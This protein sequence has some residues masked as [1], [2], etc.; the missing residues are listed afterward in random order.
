M[1]HPQVGYLNVVIPPD[2]V[3]EETSGDIMVPEGSPVKLTC[4]AHGY[5]EPTVKWRRED[6]APIILRSQGGP[7]N[8]CEM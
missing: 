8:E 7:K 1:V 4:S 5:P 3:S 2:I 6:G